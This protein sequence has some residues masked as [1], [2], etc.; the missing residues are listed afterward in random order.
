MCLETLIEQRVAML[1]VSALM[2]TDP[3]TVPVDMT[4]EHLEQALVRTGFGG[5]PVVE[6]GRLVGVVTRSDIVRSHQAESAREAQISEYYTHSAPPVDEAD[7]QREVDASAA[8]I[9]VRMAHQTAG[10]VMSRD[11]ITVEPSAPL[12]VLAQTMLDH[13]VHRVPVVEKEQLVGIVTTLDLMAAVAD[14]RLAA[15][16]D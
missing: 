4:L 1:T 15:S 2:Q 12:E 6:D 3:E 5:F 13:H 8:R 9:G 16:R 7:L 14:G 11:L 10:D